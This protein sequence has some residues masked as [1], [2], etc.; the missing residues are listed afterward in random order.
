[1]RVVFDTNILVLS[2]MGEPATSIVEAAFADTR[3]EQLSFYYSEAVFR[4]QVN[5][6]VTVNIR[7]FPASFYGIKA[8]QPYQLYELLFVRWLL[9]SVIFLRYSASSY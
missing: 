5:Y 4:A 1:V 6:L 8:L 7:H 9:Q 2:L 3:R